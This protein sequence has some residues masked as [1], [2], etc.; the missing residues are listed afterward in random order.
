MNKLDFILLAPLLFGAYQ[1][2]K[3]GFVLEIIAIISFVL[4]I[5]GGFKLMHWGM[6]LLDQYFDIGG[7]LLPYLSFILIFIGIIL[8]VNVI[9]KV[10]KKI[11]DLTLL[12]AVDNIA[13]AM[14]SLLKW[15]FGI[16]IVLWLSASFGMELPL[17]WTEGSYF[18]EPVLSFAPGFIG[19]ITDYI[20]FAHDLFDQIKE[21]LSG[22]SST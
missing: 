9:G 7:D 21:L 19:F 22:G 16:S 15:A 2:Y 6:N 18:Y 8:L 5:I 3:K 17:D 1:G 20:P 11:I 10:F 4:A 14:L 13:G 12:G